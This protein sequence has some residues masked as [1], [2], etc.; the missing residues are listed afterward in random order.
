MRFPELAGYQYEDLLGEDPFG[1]TF[2]ATHAGGKRR[3][4]K[5]LKAQATR[6]RFIQPYFKAFG[7]GSTSLAGVAPVYEF[8]PQGP[9][10]LAAC[11]L[12]F[13]GWKGRENEQ[14]QVSSLRRLMTLLSR[15][16]A[17][18]IVRD[19]AVR[20]GEVHEAGLFHGGLRPGG[21]FLTG[22]SKGGQKV[23]IADFGQIFMS[24]LQHLEA[25]D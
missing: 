24:G 20:L 7:N 13:Y 6:D 25:G 14:W 11:V 22:D 23:R 3:V 15:E 5:V 12:P 16:Q 21:I 18:A 17:V 2:V 10:T 4:I 9:D 8:V 19:L 1:W